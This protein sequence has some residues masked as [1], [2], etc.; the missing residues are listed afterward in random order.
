VTWTYDLTT[1]IGK[2]RL[3]IGDTDTNDQVLSDE[4]IATQTTATS[5]IDVAAMHCCELALA[6]FSRKVDRSVVGI[7][8]TRS[9]L[10]THFQELLKILQRVAANAGGV[11]G[12]VG[13]IEQDRKDSAVADTNYIQPAFSVGSEDFTRAPSAVDADD[14]V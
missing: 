3:R 7:N 12:Y 14:E 11:V 2:V 1:S 10:V 5:S 6:K 8:S 9:Q 4:E 13:G